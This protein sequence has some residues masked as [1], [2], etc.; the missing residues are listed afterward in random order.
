MISQ[1]NAVLLKGDICSLL[2]SAPLFPPLSFLWGK[3]KKMQQAGRNMGLIQWDTP[4]NKNTLL[5]VAGGMTHF[6]CACTNLSH[7]KKCCSYTQHFLQ[8]SGALCGSGRSGGSAILF[9]WVSAG[10]T[11]MFPP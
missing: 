5:A 8:L 10:L 7:S 3:K 11:E 4:N 6:N 9:L 2:T 1:V